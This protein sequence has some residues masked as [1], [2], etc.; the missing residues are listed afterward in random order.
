LN[1]DR[2]YKNRH[3]ITAGSAH[4]GLFV[5]VTRVL[6]RQTVFATNRVDL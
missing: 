4:A 5:E 1:D 6:K 3:V 2:N